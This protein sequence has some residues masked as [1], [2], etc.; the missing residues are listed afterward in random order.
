MKLLPLRKV[1]AGVALAIL[2]AICGATSAHAQNVVGFEGGDPFAAQQGNIT[3]GRLGDVGVHNASNGFNPTQGSQYAVLTTFSNGGGN[4]PPGSPLFGGSGAQAAAGLWGFMFPN[5]ASNQ[6]NPFNIVSGSAITL[7][8]SM[9]AGDRISFDWRFVT[10]EPLTGNNPDRGFVF[11][12]L[13]NGSPTISQA[14]GQAGAGLVPTGNGVANFD[15]MTP[16]W[17][18]FTFTATTTGT[19]RIGIG[20]GDGNVEARQSG[21]LVDNV[22]YVPEPGT[23]ALLVAG[24]LFGV[25]AYLRRRRSAA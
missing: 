15:Y 7:Q 23:T 4:Y 8:L 17:A 2:T 22:V 12:G 16:N 14:L 3:V 24:G 10:S 20:V 19:Y 25:I 9:V 21:L 11:V 13:A 5:S 6:L 18:T 1:G